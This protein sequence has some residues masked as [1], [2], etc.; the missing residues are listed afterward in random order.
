M[1]IAVTS[2]HFDVS[3]SLRD[4]I[5]ADIEKMTSKYD[6]RGSAEATLTKES[7]GF[8]AHLGMTCRGFTLSAA[9]EA[10]EPYKAFAAA[11]Q[12]LKKRLRRKKLSVFSSFRRAAY[13]RALEE[14]DS[15]N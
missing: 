5:R 7:G 13:R 3:E 4:R 15:K 6:M 1:E 10:D 8:S 9:A 14:R 11:S 2:R 12:I